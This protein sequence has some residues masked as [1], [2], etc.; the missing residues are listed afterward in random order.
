MDYSQFIFALAV[1]I[2]G[3]VRWF[4]E[5]RN[6]AGSEEPRDTT[7]SDLPE[8]TW[9]SQEKEQAPPPLPSSPPPPPR[10]RSR[11]PVTPPQQTSTIPQPSGQGSLSSMRQ[12]IAAAKKRA[13]QAEAQRKSLTSKSP[14]ISPRHQT[15]S[16][17]HLPQDMDWLLDPVSLRRAV[18]A[19]E[20]LGPPLALRNDPDSEIR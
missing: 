16:A 1:I 3:V 2:I 8:W 12:K 20:I 6:N 15:N 5:T 19:R 7:D 11:T 4:I 18:I 9:P 13:Q 10:Q 14:L 17:T